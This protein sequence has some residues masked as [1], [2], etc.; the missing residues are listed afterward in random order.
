M[1]EGH[2]GGKVSHLTAARK[3][4]RRKGKGRDEIAL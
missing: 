2:E 4:K 1:V 3:Q